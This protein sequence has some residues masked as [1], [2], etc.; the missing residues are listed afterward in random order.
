M[1]AIYFLAKHYVDDIDQEYFNYTDH[2]KNIVEDMKA[3][4]KVDWFKNQTGSFGD[5][6]SGPFAETLTKP[7]LWRSLSTF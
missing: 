1:A 3:L 2:E 6:S 5:F 7:L 4:Y